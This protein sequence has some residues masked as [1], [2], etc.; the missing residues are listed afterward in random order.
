MDDY[1]GPRAAVVVEMI[2]RLPN[3]FEAF[4]DRQL[5]GLG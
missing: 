1:R 2:K 3:S 4:V 5:S